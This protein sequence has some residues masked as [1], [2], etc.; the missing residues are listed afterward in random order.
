MS[1]RGLPND[2][3]YLACGS[4]S[5]F[6][7]PEEVKKMRMRSS[8]SKYCLDV[9]PAFVREANEAAEPCPKHTFEM[10]TKPGSTS[11]DS[12][13]SGSETGS[14]DMENLSIEGDSRLTMLHSKHELITSLMREVHAL[15]DQRW[16]K[17]LRS[18]AN[19]AS[20]NSTPCGIDG[21]FPSGNSQ[22]T[23]KRRRD[24]RDTTPPEDHNDRK[25]SKKN[26]SLAT[27]NLARLFACPLHQNNPIKY[28]ANTID[29]SKFRACAGPGFTTISRLK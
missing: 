28:C 10:V 24:E 21:C 29:G 2:T 15:F 23:Q 7:S 12:R 13:D 11:E 4:P 3:D 27:E 9:S 8:H 5:P 25:R 22:G 1:Y 26:S 6:N 20:H 19:T 17:A 16:S 14:D 18:H